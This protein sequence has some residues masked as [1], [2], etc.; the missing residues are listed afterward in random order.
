M[1]HCAGGCLEQQAPA[2]QSTRLPDWTTSCSG[3][4]S[5]LD[6]AIRNPPASPALCCQQLCTA[7]AA[8]WPA[9][10]VQG[11]CL[12]PDKGLVLGLLPDSRQQLQ[13]ACREGLHV[14]SQALND[15]RQHVKHLQQQQPACQICCTGC[16]NPGEPP[17][18]GHPAVLV[19]AAAAAAAL[20]TH[21]VG[22][23]SAVPWQAAWL[24]WGAPARRLP[25][26]A[27]A[28]L[29]QRALSWES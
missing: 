16:P 14:R 12:H 5:K 2:Q 24:K 18:S 29:G 11:P 17:S 1:Q 8:A 15:S 3:H 4:H 27:T 26:A 23:E 22:A 10:Q 25:R 13:E 19:C 6:L 7:C 28:Q 20:Q 9:L 21:I